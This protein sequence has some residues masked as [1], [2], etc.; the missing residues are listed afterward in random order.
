MRLN[1]GGGANGQNDE[2]VDMEDLKRAAQDLMT[3]SHVFVSSSGFNTNSE[4]QK[5]QHQHQKT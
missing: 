4:A 1:S 2:I 3:T 5:A